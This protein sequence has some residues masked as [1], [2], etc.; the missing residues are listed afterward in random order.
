MAI[1]IFIIFEW[2]NWVLHL[3]YQF[4][5]VFLTITLKVKGSKEGDNTVVSKMQFPFF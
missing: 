1:R 2:F 4:Y 5:N 3:F